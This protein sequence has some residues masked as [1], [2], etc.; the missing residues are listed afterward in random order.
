MSDETIT[1]ECPKT[2]KNYSTLIFNPNRNIL[3]LE[4]ANQLVELKAAFGT[5]K[6][7]INKVLMDIFITNNFYLII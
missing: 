3:L 1:S 7:L 2:F 5:P 4:I 6:F